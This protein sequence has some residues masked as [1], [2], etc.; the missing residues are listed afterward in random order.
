MPDLEFASEEHWANVL[1]ALESLRAS[2]AKLKPRKSSRTLHHVPAS[3]RVS[4]E[5]ERGLR[6]HLAEVTDLLARAQK[7]IRTARALAAA[8]STGSAVSPGQRRAKK[9]RKSPKARKSW[10]AAQRRPVDGHSF[11]PTAPHRRS[12]P[13]RYSAP[14]FVDRYGLLQDSRQKQN[15]DSD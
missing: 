2:V 14:P 6:R 13:G 15:K 11:T 9:R 7:K 4:A 10:P 8:H 5:E 3:H 12:R 1:R